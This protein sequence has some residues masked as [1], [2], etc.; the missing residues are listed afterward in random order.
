[1]GICVVGLVRWW[2]GKMVS[3]ALGLWSRVLVGTVWGGYGD[4]RRKH[5]ITSLTTGIFRG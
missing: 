3:S 2:V 5:D 4:S 1:M